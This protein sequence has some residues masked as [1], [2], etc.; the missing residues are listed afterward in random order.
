MKSWT[1]NGFILLS[2]LFSL[3]LVVGCSSSG[4]S[5]ESVPSDQSTSSD[6]GQDQQEEKAD[7]LEPVTLLMMTHWG[8]E[9]FETYFKEPVEAKFD[10]ITLEHV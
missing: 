3:F 5:K 6:Q 8:D 10:H 4:S 9:Q 1:K 7:E 2:I